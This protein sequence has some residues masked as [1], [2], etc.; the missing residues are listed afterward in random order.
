MKFIVAIPLKK[1]EN[2]WYFLDNPE[3]QIAVKVPKEAC[4]EE[5]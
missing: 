4:F 1:T 2:V 5:S 3:N